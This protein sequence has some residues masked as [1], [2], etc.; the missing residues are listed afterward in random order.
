MS[1]EEVKG[2]RVTIIGAARSGLAA[3]RLLSRTG[4]TVFLTD[5]GELSDEAKQNL[6]EAG[7]AFEE[8][9]HTDRALEADFFV[10][11]PGVPSSNEL[12]QQ[13]LH[14][15]LAVYSEI[16]AASWFCRAP[17][18][19]ITG[20][21]GK[22]TTTSLAGY[23]FTRAGRNT[24]VAGNIGFPFSDF[25]LERVPEDVVV[26]EVSSFQLDHIAAFRPRVSVLLNITPDHLD[27]YDNDF[28]KYARSK[29]RILENQKDDDVLVYNHDDVLVREYV[30]R[31]TGQR[32]LWALGFSREQFLSQGAFVRDGAIVLRLA[33]NEEML[34]APEE[35]ALRGEHNLYNSMAAALA[36]K[37]MGVGSNVI[38]EGLATFAGVPHR[39]EFVREL[40]GVKYVND[41]KATNVDAVR[42]ALGS[43]EEPIVLIAGGKDKGNDYTPLKPLVERKIRAI[44]AIGESAEKVVREL[45]PCTPQSVRADSMEAAVR[46]SKDLAHVGDVVLLSPACASFDM[47]KNYEDRGDTFKRIV[48]G[49]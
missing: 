46:K 17:V 14:A 48:L 19:A 24:S 9:G 44:V 45:G 12:V 42:Y 11:S 31:I 35:L 36:A 8:G 43:F 2:K 1:P 38:R 10:I 6:H 20:S 25:A 32:K 21:N 26:L 49:L 15:G 29:F 16:E 33:G 23:I 37:A 28:G 34:M 7:V 30:E 47:F 18:V 13:A 41:S 4:A 22:T 5:R 39:L 27:R 40:D 3:A